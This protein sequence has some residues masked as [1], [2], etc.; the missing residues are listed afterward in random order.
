MISNK[1]NVI[2]DTFLDELH[3]HDK[4]T[5]HFD[6]FFREIFHIHMFFQK[7]QNQKILRLTNKMII[8]LSYT[9]AF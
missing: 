7:T 1:E 8:S 3:L 6:I 4:P 2:I 5:N 9:G